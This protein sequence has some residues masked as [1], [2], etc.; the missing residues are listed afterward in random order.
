M[1]PPSC[2]PDGGGLALCGASPESCC[3]SEEVRGGTFYRA[4]ANSGSSP[5]S[6]GDPA[7]VSDFRLDKYDVTVGR[8]RQF[9]A[10]WNGGKGY[11]PAA[12]S[13]KHVHLNGGQGLAN[14]GSP[15]AFEP[16]WLV[17]DDSQIAPTNANLDCG[18]PGLTGYATWTN[19]VA[20]QETLPINCVNWWESYAFCI[21]DGGFLPSEA[22]W[23]YA[24][25]G[26]SEQ[27]EYPWGSTEPGTICSEYAIYGCYFSPGHAGVCVGT[28]NIAPVG[29][30]T[31]GAGR[32]GQLDLA[33][34]MW[35]WSL[36]WYA[37]SYA[38]PC[39]PIAAPSPLRRAAWSVA[40]TSTA[41]RRTSCPIPGMTT[42]RRIA[43]PSSDFAAPGR[44]DGRRDADLA[45]PTLVRRPVPRW[46]AV[47]L[48][49]AEREGERRREAT[50]RE[51]AWPPEGLC[52]SYAP[53]SRRSRSSSSA[54][55]PRPS[56]T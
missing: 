53:S 5:L 34:N 3:A 37:P 31:L 33:G 19:T 18:T 35:Q 38:S 28:S 55:T 16:G 24:A 32:W 8:F 6:E 27:R 9:V 46:S 25:A 26:G 42:P 36:D 4:Y 17:S 47:V 11:S 44:P 10:A 20:D 1:I 52:S 13:G 39:A 12:G 43:T 50:L 48:F 41:P 7:T 21:W 49:R 56:G 22:E 51:A 29:T 15:G 54:R 23:E 2:A 40:V 30:A 14:S 45:L